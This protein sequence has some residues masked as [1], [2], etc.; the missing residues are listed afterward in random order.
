MFA[1]YKEG[2]YDGKKLDVTYME[3]MLSKQK[4]MTFMGEKLTGVVKNKICQRCC[5]LIQK[6][7]VRIQR[8]CF[9]SF[10]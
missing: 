3:R 2:S 1:S 7:R 5:F 4:G 6:F 8:E 10:T 9:C